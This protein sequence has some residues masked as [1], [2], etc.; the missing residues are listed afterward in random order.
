MNQHFMQQQAHERIAGMLEDAAGDRLA[1][2]AGRGR[3]RVFPVPRSVRSAGE[4]LLDLARSF[5]RPHLA[6]E[7]RPQG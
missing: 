4:R 7:D 2:A 3:P 5:H 1:R 6:A